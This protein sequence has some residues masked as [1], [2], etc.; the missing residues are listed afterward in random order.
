MPAISKA[1][2]TKQAKAAYKARGRPSLSEKEQRQL[3]RA[4]ELER[5]AE[6]A[7]EAEKRRAEAAKKRAEKE[8][9]EGRGGNRN[10]LGTQRRTDR[11]GFKA[12]QFHL[13]AFFG[14]QNG[15]QKAQ[16]AIVE[17]SEEA[18]EDSFG[19]EDLDDEVL[20]SAL[21][22]TP[23]KATPQQLQHSMSD[24]ALMSPPSA[25]HSGSTLQQANTEPAPVHGEDLDSFW[26][27]LESSTQ[28]AR[29]LDTDSASTSRPQQ[30]K[31]SVSFSSD[32]FDLTAEDLDEL[33][34]PKPR[35]RAAAP[36][37]PKSMAP[38]PLPMKAGPR[39]ATSNMAS[40]HAKPVYVVAK[41]PHAS[42]S[43]CPVHPPL[44]A[45]KKSTTKP[46]SPSLARPSRNAAKLQK[47]I[48]GPFLSASSLYCS[49]DLGFTLSQLESF[50]DDDIQLTQ[51]V[52]G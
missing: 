23:Q 17:T 43:S 48:R 44:P 14:K 45:P 13:G 10:R 25:S 7:K 37:A 15:G 41:V 19:D 46:L 42:V 11:F 24:C 36:I 22:Q 20:L 1:L 21:D 16:E 52:P 51:A 34:P 38:P 40:S 29:E 39:N 32:D 12:S 35:S 33:D 2:T 30:E 49:P 9:L 8:K 18:D 31:K 6:A 26:D 3:E 28:I 27:D 4:L 47:A 5:R 50:V